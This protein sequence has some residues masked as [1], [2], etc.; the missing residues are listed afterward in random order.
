MIP[1]EAVRGNQSLST[2]VLP[3]KS[4][5]RDPSHPKNRSAVGTNNQKLITND[6]R[7]V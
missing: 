5:G 1:V 4:S 2:I 3:R 6:Q 7:Y